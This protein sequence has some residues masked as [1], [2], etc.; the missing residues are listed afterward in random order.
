MKI[1]QDVCCKCGCKIGTLPYI[2]KGKKYCRE[3]FQ[4]V[5]KK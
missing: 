3:C 2:Y 1:E 5:T 4:E